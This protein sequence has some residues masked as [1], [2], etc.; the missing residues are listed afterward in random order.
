ME[1]K[2]EINGLEHRVNV[3]AGETLFKTLRSLGFHGIKFGSEDGET[4]ADTILMDGRPVNS[5]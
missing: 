3:P 1:L 5:G 4:G 2:L